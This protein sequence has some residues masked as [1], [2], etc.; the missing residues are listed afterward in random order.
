VT[1]EDAAIDAHLRQILASDEF[2]PPMTDRFWD[3]FIDA[4]KRIFGLLAG[5]G[6]IGSL[7]VALIAGG[8]LLAL[9]F[10]AWRLFGRSVVPSRQP[11]SERDSDMRGPTAPSLAERAKALAMEGRWR[12]AARALH[13]ALLVQLCA[14]AGIEW[15]DAVSDWEWLS[16]LPPSPSLAEFTRSAERLA[17]GQRPDEAQFA[18]CVRLYDE[19]VGERA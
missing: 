15:R 10:R 3:G 5:L 18:N 7:V 8:V 4:L 14:R 13:Q 19:L 9:A 16:R 1:P 12:D 2:K 6:T 11:K 17:F